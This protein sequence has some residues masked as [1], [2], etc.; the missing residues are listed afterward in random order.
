VE[1]LQNP[2]NPPPV[3][4]MELPQILQDAQTPTIPQTWIDRLAKGHKARSKK[5]EEWRTT[6]PSATEAPN[7]DEEAFL[8][9]ANADE[10]AQKKASLLAQQEMAKIKA[11]EGVE[12]QEEAKMSAAQA[13]ADTELVVPEGSSV[14]KCNTATITFGP[15]Q[16]RLTLLVDCLP[17]KGQQATMLSTALV[18]LKAAVE[19]KHGVAFWELLSY[20]DGD[21]FL[22]AYLRTAWQQEKPSGAFLVDSRSAEWRACGDV[23]TELADVVIRGC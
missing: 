22:A 2:V 5:E 16:P 23:L 9:M 18:P 10:E 12:D 14:V 19:K 3:E 15:A 21:S 1:T 17:A 8:A 7:Q 6:Q 20:R 11:A 13:E 4:Q